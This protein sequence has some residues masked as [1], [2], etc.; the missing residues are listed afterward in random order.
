MVDTIMAN[1]SVECRGRKDVVGNG[2]CVI[3]LLLAQ[4]S[5]CKINS[6]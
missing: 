3:Y 1:K 5:Y 2:N 6:E 4:K